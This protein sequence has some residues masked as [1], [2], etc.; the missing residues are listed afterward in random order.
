LWSG[1]SGRKKVQRILKAQKEAHGIT[2]P[3]PLFLN[4]FLPK[5][6]LPEHLEVLHG[7][8]VKNKLDVCIFDP[9][10]MA[11]LTAANAGLAGNVYAMG[12]V[13]EPLTKLGQD[14][15]CTIET[16]HH[17][18]KTAAVDQDEPCSLEELSQ[19]GVAEWCGQ[20]ILLAR[21]S[22]YQ[23]DGK[24]ELY[25]R[26]GG[27]A[28]HASFW[29]LDIDEG[30]PAEGPA[31]QKWEVAIRPVADARAETQQAREDKKAKARE[32]RDNDDRRRMLEAMRRCPEGDTIKKLSELAGMN[33]ERGAAAIRSLL[34][35]GRIKKV[36]IKKHTRTETG[37]VAKE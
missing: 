37:Y 30:H 7:V 1:E 32:A 35:E 12:V 3:I 16:C 25:M 8:I 9:L 10:Y 34:G 6:S 15:N 21:R 24:H 13:L 17:F 5:L 11:L 29:A 33:N 18:K 26:V 23:S 27:R 2:W 4:F 22:P 20:W 31:G 28:G 36:D 19:A 14:T